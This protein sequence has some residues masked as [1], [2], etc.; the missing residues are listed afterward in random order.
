MKNVFVLAAAVLLFV[1]MVWLS[2][3]GF[4]NGGVAMAWEDHKINLCHWDEG[5]REYSVKSVDE[6]SII[7]KE[8]GV[9]KKDGHGKHEEDIIPGF[10]TD[11]WCH[12]SAQGDQDVLKNGCKPVHVPTCEEL[13][14]CPP[15]PDDFPP[16]TPTPVQ[17]FVETG[18]SDGRSSDPGATRPGSPVCSG[19][20][21]K[22]A[23]NLMGARIDA[24]HVRLNWIPSTDDHQ[25]QVVRF[26]RS[27]DDLAYS[28]L[29]ISKGTGEL[30][31]VLAPWSG[32]V[33]F[34]VGTWRGDCVSW[35]AVGD[36]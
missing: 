7:K 4:K 31:D 28:W 12:F 1:F 6:N 36:P 33:F 14:N 27:P 9:C 35:S 19:I 10:T 32:S 30:N 29:D 8:H 24:D 3:M 18:V 25:K 2:L 23:E 17:T 16:P 5:N 21:A 13:Q 26:G 20:Y 34:T 22:P 11:Q 15:N